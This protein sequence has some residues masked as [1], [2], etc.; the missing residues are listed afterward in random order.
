MLSKAAGSGL[1]MN[2]YY[3][4]WKTFENWWLYLAYKFG[5]TDSEPLVFHTRKDVTVEVPHRLV[6]TFKEIFMD[7]CYLAGLEKDISPGATIIDVGANAGYFTLFAADQFPQSRIFSF[8][9]VPVN[10]NQLQRHSNLNKNRDIKCYPLAVAGQT[11]EITLSFDAHDSFTTSAT[12]FKQ[13]NAE[14]DSL[15]VSCVSLQELMDEH[16]IT[17]C[18]LLKMDC[19]GAEYDILYNTS[20]GSLQR[21]D[22]IAMEVHS[23]K[24]DDQ[25]IDALEVF[26]QRHGFFTRRRPVGMLWAWRIS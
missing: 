5:L 12:M 22:Q 23:G 11:G 2:R 14:E 4:L 6:Q 16:N 18:D 21:I 1:N 17:K 26:L 25:N 8:E 13:V 19:E 15:K 10:Y 20:A 24:E 9:P 3:N 7:E